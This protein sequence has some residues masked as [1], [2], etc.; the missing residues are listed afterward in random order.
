MTLL[1]TVAIAR[2]PINVRVNRWLKVRQPQGT[3]IYRQQGRS[4][5]VRQGDRLQAVGDS[6]TTGKSSTAMLEVDTGIGFI[7]LAESTKVTV[8][9]LGVAPDNGRITRLAIDYGQARLQVRRFTHEGSRLELQTPAGVSAVRGTEYGIAV[10]PDGKTGL[11]TLEG[12]V[13][14]TAQGKTV[15]VSGGLQTLTIPGQQPQPPVPLQ[16]STALRYDLERQVQNGIRRVRFIGYVDPVNTVLVN[17]VPQ[18]TTA[19]GQFSVSL[20]AVSSP[21]LQVTVITPLGRQQVHSL[22]L[23]L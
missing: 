16:D 13:T 11:A 7:Q 23:R 20:P 10:Q 18:T 9:S 14:M 1:G 8:R 5:P 22:S 19:T 6:V 4:R 12:A 2:L 17:G 3:V 21:T 15:M